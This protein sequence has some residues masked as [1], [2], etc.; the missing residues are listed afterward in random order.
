MG[1]SVIL[2]S[3]LGYSW[4]EDFVFSKVGRFRK[5]VGGQRGLARRNPSYARDGGLFLHP[6]SYASLRRR[7]T[8]FWTTFWLFLGVCESP[9]PSC[10]PL[11]ETSDKGKLGS[12]TKH[13]ILRRSVFATAGSFGPLF[14]FPLCN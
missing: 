9:T 8:H 4:R 13:D 1:Q 3:F 14:A 5:G 6:F 2:S 12:Q 11:F 7:G 10:Q